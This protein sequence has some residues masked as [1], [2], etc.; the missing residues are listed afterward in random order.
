[1]SC[2]RRQLRIR[3]KYHDF[4][5]N[6][7]TMR[8]VPLPWTE[9]DSDHQAIFREWDEIRNDRR[10]NVFVEIYM[11]HFLG[12]RMKLFESRP[13]N[14]GR[15]KQGIGGEIMSSAIGK[16]PNNVTIQWSPTDD[17]TRVSQWA[18]HLKK[19]LHL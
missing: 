10:V 4:R 12:R 11:Y 6:S 3:D 17:I 19:I 18:E 1:M 7:K 9:D 14:Y 16:Y 2:Y 15:L 13:F 8:S 5:W